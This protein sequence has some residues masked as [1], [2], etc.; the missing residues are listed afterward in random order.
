MILGYP[1][2]YLVLSINKVEIMSFL[3]YLKPVSY[4]YSALL[5]LLTS[6]AINYIFGRSLDKINMIESLKSVE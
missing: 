6:F 1:L 5:A 3:Y 4:V 2:T